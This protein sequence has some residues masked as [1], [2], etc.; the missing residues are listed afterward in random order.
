MS[1]NFDDLGDFSRILPNWEKHNKCIKL[2]K[3]RYARY[4]NIVFTQFLSISRIMRTYFKLILRVSAHK[5]S[6][7]IHGFI[8]VVAH[9]GFHIHILC[10]F[11]CR[12]SENTLKQ[13]FVSFGYCLVLFIKLCWKSLSDNLTIVHLCILN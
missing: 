1:G 5:S 13:R 7:W 6:F 9:T 8:C 4:R 2:M 12:F 11:V 10:N 3:Q